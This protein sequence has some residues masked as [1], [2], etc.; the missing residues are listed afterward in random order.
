[1][2]PEF[3]NFSMGSAFRAIGQS[4]TRNALVTENSLVLPAEAFRLLKGEP[5]E[6]QRTADSGL[7][8]T[9]WACSKCGSWICAG[10]R[11]GSTVRNVRGGILDD[12]SWLRPTVHFWTRSKQPWVALP[13]GDQR[14]ETQ[15]ADM[16]A[17]LYPEVARQ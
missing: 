2:I 11:P 1:M 10:P 14:F 6:I 13:E 3:C 17:F 7:V 15:P 8:R 12:T 9:R 5:Q 16:Q 4:P